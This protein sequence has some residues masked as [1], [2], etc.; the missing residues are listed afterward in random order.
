VALVVGVINGHNRNVDNAKRDATEL[1]ALATQARQ[2]TVE[3]QVSQ[4][5]PNTGRYVICNHSE[6]P[7][8]TLA[9]WRLQPDE[10]GLGWAN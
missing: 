2:V 10:I 9:C 3:F 5:S 7:L 8:T 1:D 6:S 4:I